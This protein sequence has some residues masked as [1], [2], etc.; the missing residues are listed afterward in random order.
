MWLRHID[1]C[2][3]GDWTRTVDGKRCKAHRYM[4]VQHVGPIPDGLQLDHL[5]RNRACVNP[6]HLEPVT[7]RENLVRGTGFVAENVAKERCHKG[8]PFDE[9]NTFRSGGR[10]HC[11]ACRRDATAR[12][13]MRLAACSE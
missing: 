12:Y 8:H 10:R 1:R 7:A 6:D 9:A 13:R 11:R 5:C 2:G 3:Y 4:Y